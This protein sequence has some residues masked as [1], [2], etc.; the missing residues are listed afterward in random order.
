MSV[1]FPNFIEYCIV[2]SYILSED[3]FLITPTGNKNHRWLIFLGLNCLPETA[4]RLNGK[5]TLCLLL[6]PSNLTCEISA[7]SLI[8]RDFNMNAKIYDQII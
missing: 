5:N 4:M 1:Q 2:N 6:G 3:Q 7:L 8:C